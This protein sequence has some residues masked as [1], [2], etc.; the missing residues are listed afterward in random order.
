MPAERWALRYP[1]LDCFPRSF[2]RE[3]IT[4]QPQRRAFLNNAMYDLIQPLHALNFLSV[5]QRIIRPDG[6]D[7]DGQ[8]VRQDFIEA[9]AFFVA[10]IPYQSWVIK[11]HVLQ[12]IC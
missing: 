11:V 4:A 3:A 7:A 5:G 1:M 6:A 10:Q 2:F 8:I 9:E 12:A